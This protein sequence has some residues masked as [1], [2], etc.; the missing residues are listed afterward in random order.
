MCTEPEHNV[1]TPLTSWK[2]YYRWRSLP[3]Q[4]P[5]AVLLHWVCTPH[6]VLRNIWL[7]DRRHTILLFVFDKNMILLQLQTKGSNSFRQVHQEIIVLLMLWKDR[8][9]TRCKLVLPVSIKK[10]MII[11]SLSTLG[12][13]VI[14]FY[15][16]TYFKFTDWFH[17][18]ANTS[19]HV[20]L[21]LAISPIYMQS[22]A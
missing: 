14:G 3:L 13:A 1:S 7:D 11:C 16:L 6:Q 8:M 22:S 17:Y 18:F 9:K 12:D 21:V 2:D 20:V 5:V 10:R 19:K 4:S 15:N